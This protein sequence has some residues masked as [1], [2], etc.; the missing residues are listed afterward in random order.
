MAGSSDGGAAAAAGGG[1]NFRRRVEARE[2]VD[3][4]VLDGSGT[5]VSQGFYWYMNQVETG[6]R[7]RRTEED[8]AMRYGGSSGGGAGKFPGRGQRKRIK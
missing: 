8:R 3:W 7:R 6:T 1:R 2:S 5:V 4:A